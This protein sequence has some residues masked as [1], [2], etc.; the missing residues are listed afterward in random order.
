MSWYGYDL[1]TD[2]ATETAYHYLTG[3][4]VN[5][6]D[7]YTPDYYPTRLDS[8]NGRRWRPRHFIGEPA[9]VYG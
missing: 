1:A 8:D 5:Y 9:P 3:G 6:F 7:F 4:F 2:V